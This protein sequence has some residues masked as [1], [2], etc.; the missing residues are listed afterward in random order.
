[1]RPVRLDKSSNCFNKSVDWLVPTF[2]NRMERQ[3]TSG[4]P[5][6]QW[7]TLLPPY[8]QGFGGTDFVAILEA[9]SLSSLACAASSFICA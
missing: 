6:A 7:P 8:R 1:M 2:G 3:T 9:A 4:H 5:M